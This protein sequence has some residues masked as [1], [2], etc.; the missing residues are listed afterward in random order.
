M[1]GKFYTLFKNKVYEVVECNNIKMLVLE[2]K[3]I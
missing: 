1:E 2:Q 3:R